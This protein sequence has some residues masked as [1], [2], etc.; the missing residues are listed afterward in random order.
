MKKQK[1]EWPKKIYF[2]AYDFK[3]CLKRNRESEPMVGVFDC[4]LFEKGKCV[5][6]EGNNKPIIKNCRRITYIF[7]GKEKGNDH[8]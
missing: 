4:C 6:R 5:I 8:L 3:W 7:E 2:C 1:M